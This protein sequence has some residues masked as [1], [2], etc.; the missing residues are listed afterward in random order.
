M[1]LATT[2]LVLLA[3]VS[4]ASAAAGKADFSDRMEL[5]EK[6]GLGRAFERVAVKANRPMPWATFVDYRYRTF[7][8]SG[9]V[10]ESD[11]GPNADATIWLAILDE[12]YRTKG[13][14]IFV[15][16]GKVPGVAS[17]RWLSLEE[18]ERKIMPQV[19][20]SREAFEGGDVEKAVRELVDK[21]AALRELPL[22]RLLLVPREPEAGWRRLDPQSRM[23]AR[24]RRLDEAYAVRDAEAMRRSARAL[25]VALVLQ[26]GYPSAAK[27]S[28]EI[29]LDKLA[30]LKVG[31]A[32]YV[33]SAL[34]FFVW[35]AVGK[36]GLADAGAWV[37]FA[38]F[39]LMTAGLVGR[40]VI[41][42]HLPTT[43]MY[44]YLVSFSWTA[45]LFFL[46]FYL[47]TRGA[48]IGVIVMPVA[49]LLVVFASLFPADIEAQLIPALQ[50]L[51]IHVVLACLGE[52]AFA[53]AFAAAVLRL[54]RSD[55]PSERLPSKERLEVV[56]YRAVAL[57]YPL[58]TIGALV[59]GAIW[60]QKAWST[61]WSWDPKET[62]SLVVFLI[63]TAYLHA[64][65]ARGWRGTRAAALAV[66]IFVA[67]VFTLFANLIFGGLHS[68]GP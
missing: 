29:Y 51:T 33:L 64:R 49:F 66:L 14:L 31:F 22:S 45:V 50:S 20:H 30:V 13:R 2:R 43:S 7:K 11:L 59:A 28:L 63:A 9:K 12:E 18:F 10:E 41:A 60:A 47:K 55:R 5:V 35:A 16:G 34:F 46:L 48:F 17:D 26:P 52:G 53:V 62:A 42:G 56:E 68:Y 15:K 37:A 24:A 36:R 40:S 54:F 44:E 38:G 58:F 39:V 23:W 8:G 19:V 27:L 65:H 61:W 4:A 1:R 67:A 57:G 6:A 21:G 3:A 32:L 25:A